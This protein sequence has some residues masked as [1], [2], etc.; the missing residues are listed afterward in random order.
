M[1][2]YLGKGICDD[3]MGDVRGNNFDDKEIIE[4]RMEPW[5]VEQNYEGYR[6]RKVVDWIDHSEFDSLVDKAF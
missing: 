5:L 1:V 4:R 2:F 3:L 6:T